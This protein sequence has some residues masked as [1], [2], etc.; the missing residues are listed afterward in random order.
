MSFLLAAETIGDIFNRVFSGFDWTILA[1]LGSIQNDFFT[2]L[3]KTF[4][5]LGSTTYGVLFGLLGVVLCCFR[6]TRRTGLTIC[7]SVAIGTILTNFLIKPL[8]LRVRPYNL[9]QAKPGLLGWYFGAGGICEADYCFPSGH[10]TGATELAISLMLCHIRAKK[11]K[12]AWIFPLGAFLTGV[13]RTYLMVHYPTDII[14]GWL[15][16]SIAAV[17]GYFLSNAVCKF[18][19]KR[20]LDKILDLNRY[21]KRK[22]TPK[23]AVIG[24]ALGWLFC[25]AVSATDLYLEYKDEI[26]RCDY[27]GEYDCL[28]AAKI[29]SKKYPAI[30]GK[31]YCKIHWKELSKQFEETGTLPDD[32]SEPDTS[33][34]EGIPI[35]NS[36][37]FTFFNEPAMTALKD[38]FGT[39][40]PVK[41]T[42]SKDQEGTAEITD[43]AVIKEVFNAL[44]DVKI[45]DEDNSGTTVTDSGLTFTFFMADSTQLT[46]SFESPSQLLYNDKVY[47]VI[48]NNNIY[49]LD[50]IPETKP[51]TE[52]ETEEEYEEE[53]YWEEEE[54]YEEDCEEG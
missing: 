31:H 3:A 8:F 25:F 22:V 17:L 10:T 51:E 34:A 16:G 6:R 26:P 9:L 5:A 37:L 28:N 32:N 54:W 24:I 36:D 53:E 50:V 13:S 19:R 27:N 15:I 1:F 35:P 11:G 42:V 21:L 29:D 46:V 43:T 52:P 45:A 49:N 18:I 38:N 20:K 23:K 48:N 41:M 44:K 33:I 4:T 40:I 30:D 12:I 47:F 2:L 7:F 14:G 39:N